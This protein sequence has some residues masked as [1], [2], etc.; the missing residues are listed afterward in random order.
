MEFIQVSRG[1]D[2]K[3][4]QGIVYCNMTDV[5]WIIANNL[6]G[7]HVTFNIEDLFL[8]AAAEQGW[9]SLLPFTN[10]HT[11]ILAY[12]ITYIPSGLD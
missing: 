2:I 9:I 3:K 6:T 1:V 7:T 8:K 4:Q 12:R 11:D 10:R 5:V